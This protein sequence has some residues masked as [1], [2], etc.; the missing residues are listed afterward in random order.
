LSTTTHHPNTGVVEEVYDA[1]AGG[2]LDRLGS[3]LSPDVTILMPGRSP[4]AGRY[5]GR[6]AVFGVL[7]VMQATAGGTDRA[8]LRELYANDAQVVAVHH[9]TATR[10]DRTLDADAAL[11]FEVAGDVVTAI[12]VHQQRQDGWDDFFS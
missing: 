3:L 1:L 11:V 2:D 7:G 6:D 4:L 8:E 5:E 10:G 9:G 12:T